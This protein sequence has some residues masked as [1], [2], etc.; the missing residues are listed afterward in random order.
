MPAGT[1]ALLEDNVL[2]IPRKLPLS[3]RCPAISV[4]YFLVIQARSV[5]GSSEKMKIPIVIAHAASPP[6]VDQQLVDQVP[7][8]IANASPPHL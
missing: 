5:V 4:K 6:L 1:T 3:T 2:H 7:V 8:V